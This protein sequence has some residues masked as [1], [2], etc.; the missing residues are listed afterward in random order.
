LHPR[1]LAVAGLVVDGVKEMEDD[2]LEERVYELELKQMANEAETLLIQQYKE[3][4]HFH[5]NGD[6]EGEAK[7]KDKD[8]EHSCLD[9]CCLPS[10]DEDEEAE[11]Q[12]NKCGCYT[13][14]ETNCLG[15]QKNKTTEELELNENG[16]FTNLAF[17]SDPSG[18][19]RVFVTRE[20]YNSLS[21]WRALF[22]LVG[23]VIG[24][25]AVYVFAGL[26]ELMR[27]DFD[28]SDVSKVGRH[29]DGLFFPI[30][31]CVPDKVYYAYG[32]ALLAFWFP[33]C[34]MAAMVWPC[35]LSSLL[36]VSNR[37]YPSI[38]FTCHL[39]THGRFHRLWRLLTMTLKT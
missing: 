16:P 6:N 39:S 26:I 14:S 27:A 29:I 5:G 32:L 3:R 34:L 24:A 38:S 22:V 17:D 8:G 23:V 10:S 20:A 12:P 18:S 7:G 13:S 21:R 31:G 35:W 28:P 33:S 19:H 36:L 15:F 2:I 25:G 4:V 11:E 9:R 1:R 37:F 30:K